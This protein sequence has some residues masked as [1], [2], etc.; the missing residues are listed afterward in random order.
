MTTFEGHTLIPFDKASGGAIRLPSV[1]LKY[2]IVGIAFTEKDVLCVAFEHAL[3]FFEYAFGTFVPRGKLFD[4]TGEIDG[5]VWKISGRY[6]PTSDRTVVAVSS[7]HRSI[8]AFEFDGAFRPTVLAR[9]D[10]PNGD[11]KIGPSYAPVD[12]DVA[13]YPRSQKDG[14]GADVV[15]LAGTYTKIWWFWPSSNRNFLSKRTRTALNSMMSVVGVP[16][17]NEAG[18]DVT[19]AVAGGLD[20]NPYPQVQVYE[21]GRGIR[22]TLVSLPQVYSIAAM[23]APGQIAV[24]MRDGFDTYLLSPSQPHYST[25]YHASFWLNPTSGIIDPVN[26]GQLFVPA[27]L[28]P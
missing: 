9:L 24:V 28:T 14:G 21:S 26:L 4:L 5:D 1:R 11:P 12:L 16:T 27:T 7:T 20:V 25:A 8:A 2:P 13:P 6:L 10:N 19:V 17:T 23:S 15:I 22:G 18:E 3:Q